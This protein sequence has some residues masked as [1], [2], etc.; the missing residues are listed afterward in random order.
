MNPHLRNSEKRTSCSNQPAGTVVYVPP[1]IT[2]RNP[3]FWP[4]SAFKSLVRNSERVTQGC[5]LG[6]S[7]QCIRA[8]YSSTVEQEKATTDYVHCSVQSFRWENGNDC[9]QNLHNWQGKARKKT[10][11]HN[12]PCAIALLSR[13]LKRNADIVW[14]QLLF[15]L[16]FFL[17]FLPFFLVRSLPPTQCRCRVIVVPDHTQWHTYTCANAHTRY[18]SSGREIRPTRQHTTLTR[19]IS[20]PPQRFEPEIPANERPKTHALDRAATRI[21]TINIYMQNISLTKLNTHP[22]LLPKF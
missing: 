19:D 5:G 7:W 12:T 22:R 17:S 4:H 14:G 13:S 2:L 3:I 1:G 18:D 20:M 8:N 9:N 15:F 10:Q 6:K 11:Y 21:G 16:S